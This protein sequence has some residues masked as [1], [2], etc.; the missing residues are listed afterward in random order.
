[1]L[2]R[3]D[4]PEVSMEKEGVSEEALEKLATLIRC[5]TE[6]HTD[7]P[8][9]DLTEFDRL[10]TALVEQF[11]DLFKKLED[12]SLSP[13]A[14]IYKWEGRDP[15][16]K[17]MLFLGHTDV[18]PAEKPEEWLHPPFEGKIK[19]GFLWGRGTQDI[20]V[21]IAA[22]F[23][24]ADRLVQ[25][26]FQPE[27]TFYFA[28]GGDEEVSGKEGAQKISAWFREKNI[29][30]DTVMDEGG[31]IAV[32]QLRAF[33]SV[34]VALLGIEEKGRVTYSMELQGK[35]G[36][37]SMPPKATVLGK[38]TQAAAGL[39]TKKYPSR[40]P[41]SVRKMLEGLVP[42]T[43]LP[44]KYL[45]A[46]LWLFSPLIRAVFSGNP[47]TNSMIRTTRTLT[48]FNGGVRVNVLPPSGKLSFNIAL[49]PGDTIASVEQGLK[50]KL[51]GTGI[52]LIQETSLTSC[53]PVRLDSLDQQAFDRTAEAVS[54]VFPGCAA[55]PFMVNG[56]TDSKFYKDL[57]QQIIRF[58]PLMMDSDDLKGIHGVNEKVS[59]ENYGGAVQ[60]YLYLFKGL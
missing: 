31:I 39:V 19:E 24:A 22:M 35:G 28:F 6:S 47:A 5:R 50:R 56:T 48:M 60:Y 34:P 52:K 15:S 16:L 30:F 51:K 8:D 38:L 33:T 12:L 23:E 3:K 4:E 53:D 21:Q 36:H 40:L 1:M 2:N 20:K 17:P 57:C 42:W 54:A 14:R 44:M 49:L 18:V 41:L 55:V 46:N 43:K 37:A 27:H 29:Q 26:G 45:L 32:D 10:N 9:F 7:Y 13:L 25:R 11:P 58:T 59:L